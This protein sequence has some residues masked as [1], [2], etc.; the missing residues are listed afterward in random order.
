MSYYK[1]KELK[2]YFR[3]GPSTKVGMVPYSDNWELISESRSTN[4]F[5]KI[6]SKRFVFSHPKNDKS[7]C[8]DWVKTVKEISEKFASAD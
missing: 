6:K 7:R 4:E 2:G 1:G 8:H 5:E 3:I